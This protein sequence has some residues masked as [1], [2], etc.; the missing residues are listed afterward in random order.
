MFMLMF[1]YYP[2]VHALRDNMPQ[3]PEQTADLVRLDTTMRMLT[4]QMGARPVIQGPQLS[5]K[6]VQTPLS[7]L[8]SVSLPATNIR[9]LAT[10]YLS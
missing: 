3:T 2:Q 6:E 9:M 10:S 7:A 4:R 1:I 8:V 5:K